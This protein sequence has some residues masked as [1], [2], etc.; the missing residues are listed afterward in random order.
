MPRRSGAA[1]SSSATGSSGR[2]RASTPWGDSVRAWASRRA[3]GTVSTGTRRRA[4]SSSMRSSC[5][6]GSWS[7]ASM[8]RRTVRRPTVEQ[9]EHGAAPLDLVAAELA[10]RA[11]PAIAAWP[12]LR[13]PACRPH[14]LR[15]DRR[16]HGAAR[17][18]P[19]A[20]RA[21]AAGRRAAAHADSISTTARQAMPSARPRAPRPSARVAFTETGA[22]QDRAQAL[23]HGRGV[24]GQARGVGDDGAVGV[25]AGETRARRH[26]DHLGQQRHAVGA[27]PHRVGVGEVPA[28][29]AQP[30]RAQHGVGQ[31]VADGVGVAVPA[32]A[33]GALD[34]DA[35]QHERA[36]RVVG[37][38]VDVDALA[39]AHAHRPRR[40]QPLGRAE[41]VGIG[42]LEV[43]GLAGH[44]DAPCRPA[45]RPAWRR[46]WRRP[47][48]ARR[49]PGAARA[50]RKACG[51]CTATSAARSR[52]PVTRPDSSTAL[53]VSL[54]GSP[55]TAPSAPPSVTAAMTAAKRAGEAS[56]RAASCTTITAASSGTAA[57][58]QRTESARVAPPGTTTSAP[59]ARR[60]GAGTPASPGRA[61]RGPR[62]RN[63]A[64]TPPRPIR[65]PGGRP[66]R[67]TASAGRS[68][69][70]NPRP[71]RSTTPVPRRGPVRSIRSGPR[72]GALRPSPRPR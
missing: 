25:G 14:R 30:D 17:R 16:R 31:R 18:R 42:D 60:P 11:G 24:R 48:G 43:A 4:A 69:G 56:G 61:A 8:I 68:A 9:L 29:V 50:A 39:D 62:R 58:P 3:R 34:H 65:A 36:V 6:E 52:V 10:A 7:S 32:Q 49:G 70:P 71:R 2:A 35:A 21:S 20:R 54:G 40:Q 33:P 23:D 5:G 41:V 26:G 1:R 27:L 38:A 45:P 47:P 53:M 15:L 12:R 64:G 44:D 63:R 72:S 67:R 37:E 22:P 59:C 28:E 51:V 66:R 13:P 46:R 19:G 55:G 57:R